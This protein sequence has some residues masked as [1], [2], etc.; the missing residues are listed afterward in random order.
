[1]AAAKPELPRGWQGSEVI[2]IV[3]PGI[4]AVIIAWCGFWGCMLHDD[5]TEEFQIIARMKS[6]VMPGG[7]RLAYLS[8]SRR[9]LK[10]MIQSVIY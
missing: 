3:A 4:C 6:P 10:R 7:T 2:P 9:P 5:A 1:M 8:F